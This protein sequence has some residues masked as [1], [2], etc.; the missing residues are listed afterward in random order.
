MWNSTK[1]TLLSALCT[2]YCAQK[3]FFQRILKFLAPILGFMSDCFF[4]SVFFSLTL[5]QY[6]QPFLSAVF[7]FQNNLP[8]FAEQ[9]LSIYGI[10]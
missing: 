5:T 7:V 4:L 9:P 6:T 10:L 1:L 2:L 8:C 3:T